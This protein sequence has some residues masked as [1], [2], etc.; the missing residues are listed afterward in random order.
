MYIARHLQLPEQ[1]CGWIRR[2]ALL[3][4]LGELAVSNYI[5]DK[6][7]SLTTEEWDQ[8]KAHPRYTREILERI[9]PFKRLAIVAGAHHERLDGTG[10]P[11]GLNRSMKYMR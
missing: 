4:D 10:Y 2:A 11:D 8:I 3:H 9:G 1:E 6:P 5:L 7:G